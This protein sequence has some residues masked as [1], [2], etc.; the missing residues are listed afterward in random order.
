VSF[1]SMSSG[2][3]L[4]TRAG[5]ARVLLRAEHPFPQRDEFKT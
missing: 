3:L 2:L 1:E 4:Q 5:S